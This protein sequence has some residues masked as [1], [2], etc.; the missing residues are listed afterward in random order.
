MVVSLRGPIFVIPSKYHLLI[1]IPMVFIALSSRVPVGAGRIS[2]RAVAMMAGILMV[3]VHLVPNILMRHD[4][5]RLH[6]LQMDIAV[7]LGRDC[8][9]TSIFGQP[10]HILVISAM[11]VGLPLDDTGVDPKELEDQDVLEQTFGALGCTILSQVRPVDP[12]V[13]LGDD[14]MRGPARWSSETTSIWRPGR[15]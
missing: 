7:P 12:W 13:A 8:G 5:E 2:P 6:H 11:N 9:Q 15:G 4:Y 1:S 10:P 14:G 3:M